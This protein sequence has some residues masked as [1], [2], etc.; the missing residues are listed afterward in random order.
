MADYLPEAFPGDLFTF[1]AGA[2][3]TG[4]QL[5]KVGAA[6]MTVIP[7]A[8]AADDK[9]VGVASRDALINANIGI[10]CLGTIHRLTAAGAITRG[11]RVGPGAV[12]GAVS[13]VAAA[14]TPTA[15]EVNLNARASRGIALESAADTAIVRVMFGA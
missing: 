11:D 4:G 15:A 10:Y 7:T 14:A 8:A 3:I 13:T 1:I 6:D 2:A 5:V 12:A 9:T